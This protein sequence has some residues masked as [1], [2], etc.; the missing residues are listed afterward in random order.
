MPNSLVASN[1]VCS[2]CSHAP[3]IS[4]T[5]AFHCPR[6]KHHPRQVLD[7]ISHEEA[8]PRRV[9][10]GS[11]SNY[12]RPRG[13]ALAGTRPQRGGGGGTPP[14]LRTP[15]LSHG[16]VCFVGAGGAADFVLGIRRGG[17]FFVPPHVSVLKILRILW[18]IQKW[19][20]STKR[21]CS[22]LAHFWATSDSAPRSEAE[23]LPETA[24]VK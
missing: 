2:T 15:K 10:K 12:M 20:K 21:L 14:P 6:C 19:L 9:V 23:G 13:L 11:C 22:H 16:T 7:Q 3:A 8:L 17:N 5:S 24:G 4:V 18:R 1:S